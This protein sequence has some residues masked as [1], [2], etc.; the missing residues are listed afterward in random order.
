MVGPLWLK[1]MS[2]MEFHLT[3]KNLAMSFAKKKKKWM[4]Q[5]SREK[6]S[7]LEGHHLMISF[8]CR[9]GTGLLKV[10]EEVMMWGW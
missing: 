4:E 7:N 1:T 8:T 5:E 6:S 2:T 9:I 3:I 10:K